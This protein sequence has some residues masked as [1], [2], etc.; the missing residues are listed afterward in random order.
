MARSGSA[1]D[2]FR[3]TPSTTTSK[4]RTA[5]CCHLTTT[6][7]VCRR[8][9][10]PARTP[11]PR[12]DVNGRSWIRAVTALAVVAP[13]SGCWVQQKGDNAARIIASASKATAAGSATGD[14]QFLMQI[15]KI[16]G[17]DI[18][19]LAEERAKQ[20]AGAP[21]ARSSGTGNG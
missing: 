4:R 8:R 5:C 19:R 20:L 2:G 6:R 7:P 17:Q 14:I 10:R 9:S 3:L 21:G 1:K 11:G 13:I 18:K 15:K 12:A 16:Q